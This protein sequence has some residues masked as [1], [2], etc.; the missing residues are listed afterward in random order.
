MKIIKR[1]IF[2]EKTIYLIERN[3]QYIFDIDYQLTKPELFLLIEKIFLVR[4]A[5]VNTYISPRKK[6]RRGRSMGFISNRKRVFITLKKG[7]KISF[8]P[9]SLLIYSFLLVYGFAKLLL[10]KSR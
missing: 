2:T 7:E 6:R 9:K 8:F 5:A 3:N 4:I 10:Y 1:P